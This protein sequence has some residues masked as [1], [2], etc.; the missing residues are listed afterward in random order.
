MGVLNPLKVV[1]DNYPENQTEEFEAP[2]LPD[3]PEKMG[4]RQVPFSREIF[5]ERSDFMEDP[6]KKF[7]RLGPGREVRP[8]WG[9]GEMGTL[10][11]LKTHTHQPAELSDVAGA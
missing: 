7:F 2:N 9:A 11:Y 6:P 1:I 3:D 10:W 4:Y 5:I 8:R